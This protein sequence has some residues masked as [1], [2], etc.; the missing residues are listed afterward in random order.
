MVGK[1]CFR[2]SLRDRLATSTGL[3]GGDHPDTVGEI[4]PQFSEQYVLGMIED[5]S[6]M[7]LL[8]ALPSSV[9]SR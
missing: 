9:G 3:L 8:V 1:T 4:K 7:G 5:L 6:R 2:C